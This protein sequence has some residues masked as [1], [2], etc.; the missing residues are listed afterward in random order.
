MVIIRY[1]DVNEQGSFMCT[2]ND[3]FYDNGKRTLSY[4]YYA[5]ANQLLWQEHK[6]VDVELSNMNAVPVLFVRPCAARKQIFD[7]PKDVPWSET[8]S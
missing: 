5:G 3:F 4:S 2:A 1:N 7:Q 8:T 6:D